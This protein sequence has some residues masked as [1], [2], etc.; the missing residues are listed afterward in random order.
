MHDTYNINFADK[1]ILSPLQVQNV[2]THRQCNI[3]WRIVR[4]YCN[5][6]LADISH[7]VKK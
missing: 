6:H 5:E 1:R 7:Y 2:D 3:K 4:A